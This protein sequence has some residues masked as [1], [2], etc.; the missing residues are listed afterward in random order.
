MA[1]LPPILTKSAEKGPET[2]CLLY[3][4]SF[5]RQFGH[6]FFFFCVVNLVSLW[7][8]SFPNPLKILTWQCRIFFSVFCSICFSNWPENLG[9]TWQQQVEEEES[10]CQ[11]SGSGADCWPGPFLLAEHIECSHTVH[12]QIGTFFYF[13]FC[14]TSRRGVQRVQHDS[15]KI[16]RKCRQKP[17]YTYNTAP[18]KT[19]GSSNLA[20]HSWIISNINFNISKMF[21]FRHGY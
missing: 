20:K 3:I 7:N 16:W 21:S 9:E 14:Q 18:Y 13:S 4:F 1:V 15:V 17:V 12:T 5:F 8:I 19:I 11:G 2:T 6:K 10:M